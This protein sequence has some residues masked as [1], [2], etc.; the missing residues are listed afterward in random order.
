MSRYFKMKEAWQ[1]VRGS[2]GAAKTSLAVGKLI[3]KG[4]YNTAK[5]T[6]TEAIPEMM[7]NHR[8]KVDR[9]L[10]NKNLTGEQREKL[11]NA[12]QYYQENSEFYDKLDEQRQAR[13]QQRKEERIRKEEEE[14][15]ERLKNKK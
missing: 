9:E 15:A 6:I 14:R 4:A 7:L 10:K 1:E 12:N 11:E 5:F 2:R 3:G 8:K 13:E